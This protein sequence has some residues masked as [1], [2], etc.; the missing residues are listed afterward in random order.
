[1]ASQVSVAL[2]NPIRSTHPEAIESRE[3]RFCWLPKR[4]LLLDEDYSRLSLF[5]ESRGERVLQFAT[6]PLAEN[7]RVGHDES[8]LLACQ[9]R[10]QSKWA[11]A[12][13]KFFFGGKHV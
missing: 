6:Y 13:I 7:L 12:H 11:L 1:M 5:A 4:S 3:R 10:Q 9:A 8:N 2:P